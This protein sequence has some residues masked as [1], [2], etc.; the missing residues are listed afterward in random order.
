MPCFIE[1]PEPLYFS[2]FNLFEANASL[3]VEYQ[4]HAYKH[5]NIIF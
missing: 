3:Q 2:K 4:Y 5:P 1:K